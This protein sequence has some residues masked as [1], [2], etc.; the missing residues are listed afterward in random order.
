VTLTRAQAQAVEVWPIALQDALPIL[1]I[2][3]RPP[4]ENVPLDLRSALREIYDEA[5]Y[6][7]SIDYRQIPPKPTFSQEDLAWMD[8]LLAPLR[9]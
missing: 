5:F 6:N 9:T 7:L 8:T 4:D 2:P 1:P 3:L